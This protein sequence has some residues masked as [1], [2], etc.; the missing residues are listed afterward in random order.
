MEWGRHGRREEIKGV[1][2]IIDL[3]TIPMQR[4]PHLCRPS[5]AWVI[6]GF[7]TDIKTF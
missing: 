1:I 5:S 6:E 7:N 4:A 3:C 2:I